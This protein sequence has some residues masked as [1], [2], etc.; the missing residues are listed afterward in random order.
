MWSLNGARRHLTASQRAAVAVDMLPQLKA[1][2]KQRMVEA[3]K[4][5]GKGRPKQGSLLMDYPIPDAGQS[6][7]KA[8]LQIVDSNSPGYHGVELG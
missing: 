1:E 7:D 2:A 5:A 6:R 8:S 4:T 3:G